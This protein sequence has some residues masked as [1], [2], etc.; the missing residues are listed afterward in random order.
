MLSPS[1]GEPGPWVG[2]APGKLILSG[3]HAVVYGYRAV[4]AA[5]SLRT[6]VTLR[7]RPGPSGIDASAIRDDRV[8]P[9]L[10]TILPPEGLGVTIVSDLP[11]GCGMGSSAALAIA[12]LRALAAREGRTVGF[13]ECFERGFLPERV[14]HGNPSG[15][16]HA[17]SALDCV[18]L[19]R[20]EGPEI[21]PIELPVPLRLVVADTGTPGDTAAMVAGVRERAPHAELR[22]IGA[23][24][25]MVSARLQRGEDPGALFTE[26]HLLLRRIGVSTPRL[27]HA[28]AVM[29]E[30]GATGAKLAGAG[31]G[32][33]AFGVVTATTEAAVLA[34]VT[35][36]GFRGFGVTVGG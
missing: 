2:V 18:V 26:N 27:D 7:A 23:V 6:T 8:W 31:G 28:C 29:L 25:E 3:E 33:V 32:G 16:D 24:A 11:V 4:A 36:A 21:V 1:A 13:D 30:A 20:R 15:V 14:L 19:Y 10:A 9:A 17:V 5:V 34:A 35:A 12:T 22:R